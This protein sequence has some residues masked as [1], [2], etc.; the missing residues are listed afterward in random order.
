MPI[1]APNRRQP[2]VPEC[3]GCSYEAACQ[4]L[5][6]SLRNTSGFVMN[7]GCLARPTD[8]D[9]QLDTAESRDAV[10]CYGG[11]N[12]PQVRLRMAHQ[13]PPGGG[14]VDLFENVTVNL[15][16]YTL[17][18]RE[19]NPLETITLPCPRLLILTVRIK[20]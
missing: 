19:T 7:A 8:V 12:Y 3:L 9:A 2:T 1:L 15:T 5:S 4:I 20:Y 13:L 10:L 11:V 17:F 18:D 16:G 6:S 14:T